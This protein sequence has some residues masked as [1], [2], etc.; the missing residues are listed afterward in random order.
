MDARKV[1]IIQLGRIGDML[2]VTPLFRALK[3]A[4]PANELHL[5]AGRNNYMVAVNNPHVDH[6]H[7]YT[8]R[9]LSTLRLLWML[10]TTHFDVWLDPKAHQSGESRFFARLARA[11][12][13]IGFAGTRPFTHPSCVEKEGGEH[14]AAK[15]LRNAGLLGIVDTNLRP[16]APSTAAEDEAF[17]RFRREK[18][19]GT[20]C[21]VNVSASRPE[22]YWSAD[23]WIDLLRSL[24]DP[25]LSFVFSAP[26]GDGEQVSAIMRQVP[27][28]HLYLT[29]SVLDTFPLVKH[30]HVALTV[31]T[32][33]VHIAAAYNTPVVALY[34]NIPDNFRRYAPL[35][36]KQRSVMPAKVGAPVSE[37]PAVAVGDA[38]ESLRREIA[39][40]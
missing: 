4:N 17:S 31:D 33:I 24:S 11:P 9:P 14:F 16:V 39:G 10:R 35:S 18:D 13:K 38:F 5:L 6:V 1:C 8:K 29:K 36:E 22:R 20:Y 12:V 34:G 21:A 40:G 2:L 15:T 7:V 30:A 27:G 3:Q 28:S 32:C 23:K 37:I 19:V 25:G 26:P